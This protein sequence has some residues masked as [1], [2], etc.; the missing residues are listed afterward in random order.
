VV[1]LRVVPDFADRMRVNFQP[2]SMPGLEGYLADT[3]EAFGYRGNGFAYG[4]N[5]SHR[6]AMSQAGVQGDLSLDSSCELKSKSA[7]EIAVPDGDYDV[8]FGLGHP[9]LPTNNH[10]LSYWHSELDAGSFTHGVVRMTAT[11]GRLRFYSSDHR[12]QSFICYIEI[13]KP[14]PIV[15]EFVS[16]KPGEVITTIPF[17]VTITV[18]GAEVI[19]DLTIGVKRVAR[20]PKLPLTATVHYDCRDGEHSIFVGVHTKYG[21]YFSVSQT[22]IVQARPLNIEITS[23]PDRMIFTRENVFLRVRKPTVDTVIDLAGSPTGTSGFQVSG[24]VR[25][26]PGRNEIVVTGRDG[27]RTGQDSVVLN[28]NP[29]EGYDPNADS[30]G[31][32]VP[33]GIDLYPKNPKLSGDRDN[34]GYGDPPPEKK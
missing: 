1:A 23:P 11:N 19:E 25:L 3:G 2:A 30:D 14:P 16:P 28:F 13:A 26:K 7:W 17:P 24:W 20:N 29:P 8:Y 4:W 10:V 15:V 27:E 31:D 33:D 21:T 9:T 22:V 32:G 5:E 18:S 34:D 12:G 6:D